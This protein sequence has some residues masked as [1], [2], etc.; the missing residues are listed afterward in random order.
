MI[1][2]GAFPGLWLFMF[3]CGDMQGHPKQNYLMLYYST[4]LLQTWEK[5]KAFFSDGPEFPIYLF[6]V[7]AR[8]TH[9]FTRQQK[10]QSAFAILFTKPHLHLFSYSSTFYLLLSGWKRSKPWTIFQI[11]TGPMQS[12]KT[13]KD[14]GHNWNWDRRVLRW[15]TNCTTVPSFQVIEYRSKHASTQLSI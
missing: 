2:V 1:Y 3:S 5:K 7:C 9:I 6:F 15:R 8:S 14:L 13:C 10:E 12:G 4:A 11:I